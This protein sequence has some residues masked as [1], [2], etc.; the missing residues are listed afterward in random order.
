MKTKVFLAMGLFG[1][2]LAINSC[3]NKE[4]VLPAGTGPGGASSGLPPG[5]DTTGY[6]YSSGTKTIQAII[7]AQCAVVGCHTA[8]D[9][10]A[11]YT[12]YGKLS[13]YATGGPA[14]SQ[15]YQIMFNPATTNY[16]MPKTPQPGW[17]SCTKYKIKAWLIA[18][19]PK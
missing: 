18:G 1:C 7:N 15:F 10:G 13:I 17:D 14:Y 3:V 5:C 16:P 11:N 19:A 6:T 9:P 4:G 12:T 2:I 8:G